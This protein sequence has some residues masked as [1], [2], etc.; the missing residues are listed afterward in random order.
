M[1]NNEKEPIKKK[2]NASVVDINTAKKEGKLKI[3]GGSMFDDFNSVIANQT[4]NCVWIGN[5]DRETRDKYINVAINSLMGIAPKDE[6]EGMLAA[7]MVATHN[8]AMECY[9]RAMISEQTF[10][11]RAQNLAFAGKLSRTYTMQL[12][13]LQKYR[14][15]GQ[16]KVTVEHVHVHEGGQAIVGNVER[17]AP[18]LGVGTHE[19]RKEQPHAKQDWAKQITHA[20]EPAMQRIN[21]QENA[22]PIPCD[23]KR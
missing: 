19:K 8:A 23:A 13:A 2:D 15:K 21:T 7:Q 6:I 22:L 9:R 10:E 1:S 20:P 17:P 12:E 3:I 18:L 4:A 11:G 5:A 16:Q 14:G